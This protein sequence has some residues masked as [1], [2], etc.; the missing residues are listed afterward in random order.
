MLAASMFD[1]SRLVP[2]EISLATLCLLLF[3]D[4]ATTAAATTP[5]LLTY[6]P[7][8]EPWQVGLFGATAAGL[9]STV[10]LLIFRWV[11]GAPW[12]WVQRFA[13]SRDKVQQALAS[14]PGASFMAILV[15][16]ATPLPDG[17]VKILVAAGRYPLP[18]YF[19][20]VLLGGIPYFG[21]L[22]WLGHTFP[23]PPWA[24]LLLVVVVALVFVFE[25]W[26]RRGATRD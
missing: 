8:F 23:I 4:N 18:L 19:L 12:A 9:G 5:L 17:P 22:A 1:W 24:L 14:S 25:R 7:H 10:Q 3:L 15:A 11:L 13:P 20:A 21:V 2:P 26:R 6:A 16:R